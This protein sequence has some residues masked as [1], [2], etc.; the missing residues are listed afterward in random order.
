MIY[1]HLETDAPVAILVESVEH[2]MRVGAGVCHVTQSHFL[3]LLP[4]PPLS[5]R[6][7]HCDARRQAVTL[8]VCVRLISLGGEGSALY[9]VLSSSPCYA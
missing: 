6:K 5:Q 3:L 9:P 1:N 7:R 4:S 2:E 8:C